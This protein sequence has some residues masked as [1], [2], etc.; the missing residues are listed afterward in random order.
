MSDQ[1]SEPAVEAAPMS[2]PAPAAHDPA[3]PDPGGLISDG[4]KYAWHR[5]DLVWWSLLVQI[6]AFIGLGL[7]AAI[8]FLSIG[9]SGSEPSPG[10]MIGG[11]LV[12]VL[13][14]LGFIVVM[15]LNWGAIFY[16]AATE[17]SAKFW[18]G[19]R[20][21]Y[22]HFWSIIWIGILTS[23]VAATGFV[24][25]IIPAII[26]G[27]Y[28]T[29]TYYALV[30]ENR[31]GMAAMVRS[32]QLVHG[33]WWGVLGRMLLVGL[34]AGA[35]G[36]AVGFLM[37]LLLAPLGFAMYNAEAPEML[38]MFTNFADILTTPI[39]IILQ[40]FMS[41]FSI[42]VAASMYR[43]M[44][45]QKPEQDPNA[46]SSMRT[47]LTVFAWLGIP[48]AIF[49]FVA[50]AGMVAAL[51]SLGMSDTTGYADSEWVMPESPAASETITDSVYRSQVN[52]ILPQA[53]IY[54]DA[55]GNG[56]YEGVCDSR[57]VSDVVAEQDN[58]ACN[59]NAAGYAVA[60]ELSDGSFYC[61]D[62]TGYIVVTFDE[63]GTATTCPQPI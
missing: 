35:I 24:L 60:T 12:G 31:R 50:I 42:A 36:A 5:F 61:Y 22:T 28:L 57:A 51:S 47:W 62:S 53:E 14:V 18:D 26:F 8:G 27:I 52:G 17:S 29:F 33:N 15:T 55:I 63:L 9:M 46:K 37:L 13:L 25:L 20:W 4:L 58:V 40:T 39:D 23:L 1:V 11:G 3:L 2:A 45:A 44:R 30:N 56:S 41:V 48:A 38:G 19:W 43:S 21:A 59:D 32:A 49:F 54:F 34:V 6:G 16:V 7:V 10:L